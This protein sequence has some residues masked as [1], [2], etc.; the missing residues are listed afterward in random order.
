MN[1]SNSH[2]VLLMPSRLVRCV[3]FSLLTLLSAPLWAATAEPAARALHLLGYLGADYPATVANGEVIDAGEY[4]E[5]LEFLGVLQD[6]L[7]SLP[8]NPQ[9]IELEHGVL[10]LQQAVTQRAPGVE[11]AAE[12]RHLAERLRQIYQLSVL[13][14]ITPDPQRGQALYAEQCSVCHGSAGAGDGPAGVGMQPPPS[15]F[16]RQARL[17][18]L[19]LYDLF[20]TLSL[21]IDGT[22]M[23]AFSD[24]LDERQR[25]DLAS[26]VAGFSADATAAGS[27]NFSLAELVEQAPAQ[28]LAAQ[29][30]DRAAAFRA[31]RATPPQ[32]QRG[33]QELIGHTVRTLDQSLAAY[34]SGEH[35][36]AYDLAV[37]AY[38]EGFELV[39]SGLNNLDPQLRKNTEKALMAYRQALQDG[40]P[41]GDT[42]ALLQQAKLKLHSCADL[43]KT[44]GMSASL[45]F[46]S[47]LMILLREGLEAILVLAAIL[48]FLRNTGQQ[49]SLRSVHAGWG[50]ALLAGVAT[51][52]LAAYVIDVSGAQRELLEG[53]TA[54]FA[55]VVLLW[56]GVWMHDRR[57]AAA[58]QASIRGHLQG[59]GGRFG[60]AALA[61]FAV[62]RELFEVILFYETLW[63]QAGPA[64]H[65]MVLA[66]AGAALLLLLVL[67]WV[68]LRGTAKLPLATFFSVNAILLCVLSVVYAGHG[69][70]ALQEAGIF[71][72]HPVAFFEFDWLGIHPDAWS[73]T[74]QGLALAGVL[75]L[76]GRSWLRQTPA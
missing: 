71:G 51:W 48:A 27:N 60:F 49:H 75:L 9:R 36:Q 1:Q 32:P 69:V 38:L 11:V 43:L 63:L 65:G 42:E 33:P 5:Q 17:D 3:L 53:S 25:W 21:G 4:R 20:N 12:A 58:W 47:S 54:L 18:S 24:Q 34:A 67:A 15:N 37:G 26:Y 72:A 70:K 41:L 62:Y 64:G 6:L 28:V 74:A 13:P 2:L 52:A 61:F 19:S 45:S 56:V 22:E 44:G 14:A 50:L 68:I 59:G 57:H 7:L 46:I 40:L 31:Q 23:A 16:H 30:A 76:Y 55:S 39:E 8:A 10:Q 35:E 73:L 29:G 66:G